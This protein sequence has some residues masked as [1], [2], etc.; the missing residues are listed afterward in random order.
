MKSSI[1]WDVTQRT[2]VVTD[3]SEEPIGP[4]FMD[5]E[6]RCLIH[7][8]GTDRLIRNIGNIPEERKSRGELKFLT[9]SS[10]IIILNLTI[11]C[12]TRLQNHFRKEDSKTK[13]HTDTESRINWAQ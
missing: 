10:H 12:S 3:I 2:L 7:E 11:I 4:V 8:D 13:Q 5:Q 6:V 1:Y 9:R